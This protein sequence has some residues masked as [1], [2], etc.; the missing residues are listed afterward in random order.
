MKNLK[1]FFGGPVVKTLPSNEG[2]A[3]WIPEGESRIP[4]A[5]PQKK[6]QQKKNILTNSKTLKSF[7][8]KILKMVH[9]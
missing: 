4:H 8:T 1:D 5:S 3:G 7:K 6:P 2:G 9:I